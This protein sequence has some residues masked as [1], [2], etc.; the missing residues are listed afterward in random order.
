M[1][2]IIFR[3]TRIIREMYRRVV[4]EDGRGFKTVLDGKE[5]ILFETEIDIDS[6]LCL[7]R[8]AGSNK[9]GFSKSGPV[10][11]RILSRKAIE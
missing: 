9:K 3:K 2:Q 6:L 11:V 1:K 4:L 10:S 5:E 8:K 7:G